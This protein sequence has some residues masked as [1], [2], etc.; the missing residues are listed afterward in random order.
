MAATSRQDNSF[1]LTGPAVGEININV[2]PRWLWSGENAHLP[3]QRRNSRGW[4]P[5]PTGPEPGR[6]RALLQRAEHRLS[7][8]LCCSKKASS[9]CTFMY[10]CCQ[11]RSP[12]NGSW[13]S[14][15]NQTENETN[16]TNHLVQTLGT[17]SLRYLKASSTTSI[18]ALLYDKQGPS[19]TKTIMPVLGLVLLADWCKRNFEKRRE[20]KRAQHNQTPFTVIGIAVADV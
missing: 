12:L 7:A 17:G 13:I 16:Q 5:W 11:I 18:L 4:R 19:V 15:L 3:S 2:S 10:L 20:E 8:L 14:N 9:S 1:P 6:V